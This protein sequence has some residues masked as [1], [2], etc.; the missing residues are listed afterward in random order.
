MGGETRF[1][2]GCRLVLLRIHLGP[3]VAGW[4]AI[5]FRF[6]RVTVPAYASIRISNDPEFAEKLEDIVGLFRPEIR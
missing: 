1:G 2:R 4:A 5:V 3:T 6:L